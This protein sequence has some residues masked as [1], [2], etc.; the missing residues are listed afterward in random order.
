MQRDEVLDPWSD[1]SIAYALLR[2]TF[3]VNIGLR[4]LVRVMHGTDGFAAGIMKQ[5]ETTPLT[6]GMVLPYAHTLPYVETLLGLLLVV[7]LFTRPALIVGALM[8]TSLTFG[9]MFTENFTN[10]WL[11]VTYAG[12]FFGLLALRSW[13]LISLD[14]MM[15][16]GKG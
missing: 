9:T 11:Q 3:G 7:G 10:A 4:G 6:P 12:F 14:A 16:G 8:I 1:P 2:L 15:G 13:N 5:F